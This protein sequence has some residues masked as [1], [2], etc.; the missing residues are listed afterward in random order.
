M[1]LSVLN[2]TVSNVSSHSDPR[3]LTCNV[4]Y[5]EMFLSFAWGTRKSRWCHGWWGLS[6]ALGICSAEAAAS[7]CSWRFREASPAVCFP[8]NKVL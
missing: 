7:C 2:G 8:G 4:R 3:L 5:K 6:P 1:S